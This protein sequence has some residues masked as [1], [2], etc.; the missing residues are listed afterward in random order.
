M[1]LLHL[2]TTHV[3]S[4]DLVRPQTGTHKD[5]T[6]AYV[7]TLGEPRWV[8]TIRD[9]LWVTLYL[10]NTTDPLIR[11]GDTVTL[12]IHQKDSPASLGSQ[13]DTSA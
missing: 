5:D 12:S 7:P 10:P 6:G 9:P 3:H 8:I 2:L 4:A 11:P 13:K 1:T